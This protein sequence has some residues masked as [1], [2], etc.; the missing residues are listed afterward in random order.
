MICRLI[1]KYRLSM[2]IP[3]VIILCLKTNQL[4]WNYFTGAGA[5]SSGG[6]STGRKV[7]ERR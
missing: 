1:A 6:G 7:T 4:S 5:S 2:P 3:Y